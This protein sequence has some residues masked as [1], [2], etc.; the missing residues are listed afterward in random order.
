[1]DRTRYDELHDRFFSILSSKEGTRYERLAAV[2]FKAL[3]EQHTVIHD[4]KLSGDSTV[5]HQIDVLIEV[6]GKRKRVLIEC[7]DF[8]KSGKRV[9]LGILRN[10]RSV[11]EDTQADEAFVLTCTGYTK[12]ALKYAKAKG[13]KLAVLR[14]FEDKDWEGRIKEV[15]VNL[16]IQ[17]PPRLERVDVALSTEQERI[18]RAEAAA[19]GIPFPMVVIDSPV[20]FVSETEQVQV[21]E[22]M[23]GEA[24]KLPLP[25]SSTLHEIRMDPAVWRI[26]IGL[27]APH[28]FTR[29][30]TFLRTFP[31][32]TQLLQVGFDRVAELILKGFGDDDIIIFADQLKRAKIDSAGHV[33]Y[34]PTP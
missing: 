5:K 33:V 21:L 29:F 10:F 3:H 13:I 20:Y 1:M 12:P 32:L 16:H 22:Y 27:N 30:T 7:K 4:F 18:L 15:S 24:K 34:D 28:A 6:G 11:V 26:R 14:L 23:E 8:D 9:G 25:T 31:I 17:S 19:E 2:V